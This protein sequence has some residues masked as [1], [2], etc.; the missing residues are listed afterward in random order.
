MPEI[1]MLCPID[2]LQLTASG[3][4]TFQYVGNDPQGR[5]IGRHIH[6]ELHGTMTCTNGHE[7]QLTNDFLFVRSA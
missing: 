6:A 2:N 3:P 7:W 5:T 1:V 4:M